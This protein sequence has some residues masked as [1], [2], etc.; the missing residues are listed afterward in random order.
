MISLDHYLEARR[1]LHVV[2]H[3]TSVLVNETLL[4]SLRRENGEIEN[5]LGA[6]QICFDHVL[7][8]QVF[9]GSVIYF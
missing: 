2:S 7:S 1:I 5:V 6:I 9:R 3:F 4:V 8:F